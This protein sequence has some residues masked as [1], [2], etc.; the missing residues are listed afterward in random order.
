MLDERVYWLWLQH[1]FGAGSEKPVSLGKRFKS[2]EE[3]LEQGP[4]FWAGFEFVNDKDLFSLVNFTVEQA[5]AQLEYCEKIGQKVITFS[6]DKFPLKLKD[7]DSAP[8]VLFY[9]GTFPD[10]DNELV[11]SIVSSRKSSDSAI[12]NAQRLAYDLAKAGAVVVAGGTSAVDVAV[13]RGAIKAGGRTVCVLPSSLDVQYSLGEGSLRDEIVESG[14]CVITE[15]PV[16]TNVTKGSYLVRNRIITGLCNALVVVKARMNSGTMLL[17]SIAKRQN[18]D[19]F[20]VPGELYDEY[21]EGTNQ[22]LKENAIPLLS[23]EGVLQQ[24]SQLIGGKVDRNMSISEKIKINI[25]TL[26]DNAKMVY[27]SLDMGN[28]HI[29]QLEKNTNLDISK[30][31][32]ALTELELAGIIEAHFGQR[33]TLR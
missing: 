28:T 22:L 25:E 30:V 6:C 4:Q 11:V 5:Q 14:G 33:F 9:K 23:F 24:Y 1:A 7:I 3:F 10:F 8:A 12:L 26:S 27:N 29:S 21:S 19:I 17:A 20:V 13:H 15:Y 32:S 2:L 31:L 18:K 16:N